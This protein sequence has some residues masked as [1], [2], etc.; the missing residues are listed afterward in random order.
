MKLL[1]VTGLMCCLLASTALFGQESLTYQTPPKAIA[2]IIDN[3]PTPG[4]SISADNQWLL[5]I[6]RSNLPSIDE[7]A[8]PELRIGG[9]RI[10][11]RTN[12]SSRGSFSKSLTLKSIE[13]GE[14]YPIS[15]LPAKAKISSISWAPNGS[16]IAFTHTTSDGIELWVVN[17]A[18][19]SAKKI[20]NIA[21]N[22]AMWGRPYEWL[23][24]SKDIVAKSIPATR[25]E[26]PEKPIVPSGPIISEN[27]GTVAAVRTYQDLLKN[28]YDESL[29]EY[30]AQS[31][32]VSVNIE[33]GAVKKLGEVGMYQAVEPS[34]DGNYLLI[35]QIQRPFSYLV[36]YYRFPF[37][38][39][40][41]D[42]DG[43]LVK[44]MAEIPS[45]EDIPKGFMAVRK[46][47]RSFSWR[48]DALASLYWVEALD[49]G[50]PQNEVA[51]RDEVKWLSAPFSADAT[52]LIKTKLRYAGIIWGNESF[53]L[54][55]EYWRNTRT[56]VLSSFNP[57]NLSA[58]PAVIF[59]R[60]YED[61]YSDPGSFRRKQNEWGRSVLLMDKKQKKL[62][63]TGQ[64]ASPEGNR[65]FLDEYE[66][67]SGK[68]T[69]LWRS[70]APHYEYVVGLQDIEKGQVLISRESKNDPANIFLMDLKKKNDIQL[71]SFPHPYPQ[72][73]GIQKQLIQYEREDGVNLTG[74]LY[75]PAGYNPAEDG[76]IPTLLWA[77]PREFKSANAAGQVKGSPYQFVRI[78][79]G[80]PLFWLAHGYAIL[81]D[82]GMPIVGEGDMEPNDNFVKQLVSSAK[83]AI[84]KLVEMGVAD[85][86]KVAIGG[87]SYGAFMT[88][89]LLAH[90]DL[91]TCGIA[92]SGAYNRTLTPFGFQAEER[93]FW[94][95]PEIYFAM[96]PFMH[97]NKINEPILLLHGVADNNSGTFPM[98]SERFYNALK[99]HGANARLVMLPHE[100]HGYRA[101]ES[102]LHMLWEMTVFMEKHMGKGYETSSR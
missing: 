2:D 67:K 6:G 36:P 42:K 16:H 35:E 90:S 25:G 72:L 31:Q 76:T 69:R 47:P 93:T 37:L 22:D 5:L 97:V 64:G 79:G 27:T 4:L 21:L 1:L 13:T 101:R 53:A 48:A 70:E 44:T 77:Y 24:N 10:N 32:L 83:A 84:D 58:K 85:R 89:N 82:P 63:L 34:P 100:S 81:D 86:E 52:S 66:I 95:A 98:Q 29:F 28:S 55:N 15:G 65:P 11:P 12:G 92:R 75:L 61:R 45:A 57:S 56:E 46:G 68:I 23:A 62:Y 74:N 60:S 88:A 39:Q 96:S 49:E 7:L 54:V 30:F 94:E 41:W 71:T 8:Q 78:Y 20:S 99:G 91:F 43:G 3:P 40:I 33:N 50:D 59:N 38:V 17:V 19:K 26:V 14:E 87:H 18:Q 73:K 51:Y 102:V 9:L 80:S